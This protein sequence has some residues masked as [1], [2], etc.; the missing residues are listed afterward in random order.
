MTQ[1]EPTSDSKIDIKYC[2][3]TPMIKDGKSM[4]PYFSSFDFAF[5]D[6]DV[7]NIAVTGPYGA[8]KSTVI[9]SYHSKRNKEDYINVSLAG[10]DI[11]KT[12][13]EKPDNMREVELSIL[14]Q[15]LYKVDRKTL[16]DSRIERIQNRND[17]YV[18]DTFY[19]LLLT[20]LPVLMLLALIF[21]AKVI[22]YFQFP[23]VWGTTL[24][25]H[26]ISFILTTLVLFVCSLYRITRS[27]SRIG[28]FDRKLKLS[29]ITF[30]SAT[31]ETQGQESS[32]LLNNCLDEIVYFFARSK[33]Q[34]VVF[35]DLDRLNSSEIFIKLRELNKI[36]NNSRLNEK[37]IRF[38][39][40]VKD[41]IFHG[42]DVKT[43]FFDY[44]IPIVPVMD[45][46]NA[47]SILKSKI[48]NFPDAHQQ[49]LRG[50]SLYIPDMRT[51]QNIVNEYNLFMPIVGGYS[52]KDKLFALIFYK[53][54]FALDYNLVDKK[55]GIL[56]SYMHDFRVRK[57]HI[58]YFGQ[59]E[60]QLSDLENKLERIRDELHSTPA[61]LRNE[62]LCRFIP[63]SIRPHYNFY[64]LGHSREAITAD[65]LVSN[66]ESFI[67]FCSNSNKMY[68]GHNSQN[69]L[70]KLNVND[71]N[72]IMD[73]YNKR[74]ELVRESK[75]KVLSQTQQEIA[76]VREE[77]SK[78]NA[79]S[80]AELTKL[81][82]REKFDVLATDYIKD[83]KDT[84]ILSTEQENTVLASLKYGG[85]DA[86]YYLIT[87]DYLMQD[88]MMYRS[89]FYKGSLTEEDYEYIK[90]VGIH[91]SH[92]QVNNNFVLQNIA[93]VTRDLIENNYIHRDGALHHQ[94][95]SY[96]IHNNE[97]VL[98]DVINH[99]FT[100]STSDILSFISILSNKFEDPDNFDRFISGASQ[101]GAT[102]DRLLDVLTNCESVSI[103]TRIIT[104]LMTQADLQQTQNKEKFKQYI[105]NCGWKLINEL[106]TSQVKP[107]MDNAKVLDVLYDRVAEA[108]ND[109]EKAAANYLA[110]NN[111]YIIEKTTF[112]NIVSAKIAQTEISSQDVKN[113]PWSLL[114]EYKLETIL[115]YVEVNI[116]KFVKD[117][118]ISSD[119][120]SESV[121]TM[122]NNSD[123]DICLKADIVSHMT[124][125]FK[126]HNA[127]SDNVE[128]EIDCN[129]L[130]LHDLLY[131]HDRII[132]NWSSLSKYVI[133][134]CD[135]NVLRDYLILHA[136][137]LSTSD[138]SLASPEVTEEVYLKI[139]C[140]DKLQDV[141][142]QLITK[143]LN[144]PYALFDDNISVLNLKRLIDNGKLPLEKDAYLHL[145]THLTTTSDCTEFL[146]F[147]FK[148]YQEELETDLHF[149]FRKADDNELFS[150]LFQKAIT[151]NKF[152]DAFSADLLNKLINHTELS[153]LDGIDLPQGVLNS[154]LSSSNSDKLKLALLTRYVGY[155]H[156]KKE[157]LQKLLNHLDEKELKKI[158]IN[159]K[160]AIL[161]TDMP[162]EV[163]D[164]LSTLK[165][166]D[167]INEYDDKGNGRISVKVS[168]TFKPQKM[169][170]KLL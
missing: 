28:F 134:N 110:D 170:T 52:N 139:V 9:Q 55:L 86:L 43:K 48:A 162:S 66:E 24:K 58:V 95:I 145:L 98:T 151:E 53:N 4:E 26:S 97:T 129:L 121:L 50:A 68:F 27:A 54:L 156:G 67:E 3:L 17:K 59:L 21:N 7:R 100:R 120:D 45:M 142:Y 12:E 70:V 165:D 35:E 143:L 99:L 39:Y 8:G 61:D 57:L 125:N 112:S 132:P 36:I 33:Y 153:I 96:L 65:S 93:G 81:N 115:N 119:D 15:I 101:R 71:I 19:S 155:G 146:L 62:L 23:T 109:A 77:I 157:E 111:M 107:F 147:W 133:S 51:L 122:L 161:Q 41:D 5:S 149:Y 30:L 76:H 159:K 118:F 25:E 124:F 158:F 148:K 128:V 13:K 20:I 102:Q 40:A 136:E 44:I 73:E 152:S 138:S 114:Q 167:L 150:Q 166:R 130:T 123:V 32:S 16:P 60:T 154:V 1:I 103:Q 79:I 84:N 49:C 164:F 90:S 69:N 168:Y 131:Q 140:D 11:A 46:R 22:E 31:A 163:I 56:Y 75:E 82:G 87:N 113:R 89:I 117:I 18:K 42:A 92:T 74:V 160:T 116:N 135:H 72:Q 2:S 34:T 127:V 10:F 64:T 144:I 63:K 137:V 126:D 85:L 6:N 83:I 88:F 38:I 80:L 104:S 169:L 29:K 37:P 94:V 106:Q 47:Y 14:Q 108:T 91:A 78:R 105:E 141:T